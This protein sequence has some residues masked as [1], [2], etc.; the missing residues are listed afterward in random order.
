MPL[1]MEKNNFLENNR[2]IDFDNLEYFVFITQIIQMLHY[3]E[4][5]MFNLIFNIMP[6]HILLTIYIQ[7]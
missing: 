3:Q 7:N 1:T 6:T 2:P 4:C 5:N